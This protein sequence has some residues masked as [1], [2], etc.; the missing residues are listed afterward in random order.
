MATDKAHDRRT[1]RVPSM[2]GSGSTKPRGVKDFIDNMAIVYAILI[3]LGFSQLACK[4]RN[5]WEHW[6]LLIVSSLVLIRF[7]FAP[8]RNLATIAEAAEN[9]PFWQRLLF[10]WDVPLLIAHS[11]VFCSICLYG[12]TG[13]PQNS[14]E[15]S[16]SLD[17]YGY[18]F[19]FFL[20]FLTMNV[21]WLLSISIRLRLLKRAGPRRFITWTI[22]NSIHV[23]LFMVLLLA[24]RI[25]L[26]D[27]RGAHLYLLFILAFSNC[28]FDL[29]LTAPDYLG[30]R[31]HEALEQEPP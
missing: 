5:D 19:A 4:F 25:R 7:F 27:I 30:F 9:R 18:Y 17:V 23:V 31:K 12:T 20:Y 10:L 21:V 11:F 2:T 1:I 22:N 14:A 24:D 15:P 29:M 13:D 3:A 26:I 28:L 6:Q 8:S 16:K